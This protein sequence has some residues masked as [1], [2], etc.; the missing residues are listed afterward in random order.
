MCFESCTHLW[1]QG[2][3]QII[4]DELHDLL[5]SLVLCRPEPAWQQ[6]FQALTERGRARVVDRAGTPMWCATEQLHSVAMLDTI[7][8]LCH[9]HR[10]RCKV[11]IP[12]VTP[13]AYAMDAFYDWLLVLRPGEQIAPSMCEALEQFKQKKQDS[14]AGYLISIEGGS[15]QELRFVNRRM[16][17]WMGELPPKLTVAN[18]F[19]GGI[20]TAPEPRAA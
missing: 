15:R 17:N 10:A 16:V 5:L 14:C 7:E 18:L 12:G 20:E 3:L 11:E 1:E 2:V 8:R 4:S 19:P 6:W 9:Q 13:G